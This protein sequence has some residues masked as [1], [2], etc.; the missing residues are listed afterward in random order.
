MKLKPNRLNH[1]QLKQISKALL[2]L[3]DKVQ[4]S[5]TV[6]RQFNET[7]DEDQR[8]YIRTI[9][10]KFLKW[11]RYGFPEEYHCVSKEGKQILLKI[12]DMEA[13]IRLMTNLRRKYREVK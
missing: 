7:F 10:T 13:Y 9:R 12:I 5:I 1:T 11:E 2:K 8:R 6:R 3:Y 4:Q